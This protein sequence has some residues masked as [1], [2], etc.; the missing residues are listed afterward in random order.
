MAIEDD[1]PRDRET[2]SN[3]ARFW[4]N[5][6]ADKSPTV[7]RLYHHLAIL[8][9]P[10][11]LEQLSLYTRALTCV[12]PFES[13]RGS[14]MTLFKPVLQGTDAINR[15]SSSLET[16]FIRAHGYLFTMHHAEAN[17]QF[18]ATVQELEKDG[19]YDKYISKS[20][21]KFKE[22]G[23]YCADANIAALFE[24]GTPKQGRSK[25]TLR[26]VYEDARRIREEVS[27]FE[28]DQNMKSQ[29]VVN[30]ESDSR[31]AVGL[32]NPDIEALVLS[33]DDS[34]AASISQASRLTTP[35][36]NASLKRPKDRNVY[37]LVDYYLAFFWSLL[38]VQE[39]CKYLEK[40]MVWKIIERDV[41]W[42]A[43]CLFLNDLAAEIPSM[44]ERVLAKAFPQTDLEKSRP[45]LEDFVLRGQQYALWLFP[46]KWFTETIV[47][48][49][50]RTHDPP[51]MGQHRTERIMWLGHRIASVCSTIFTECRCWLTETDQS[52]DTLRFANAAFRGYGLR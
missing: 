51:S 33:E 4:Y 52:L 26:L 35:I 9:R 44:T 5:K 36:L 30:P 48:D 49:D 50:E 25:A 6:A 37:P 11:S 22:A 14:V 45:L 7:G 39:S 46:S 3:V 29:G 13:A 21:S 28:D 31:T 1:E 15:R 18:V 2:W 24:Y 47:E 19:L 42:L 34:I 43:I 32:P 27:R 20:G 40:A 8:A 10:Y 41:P 17:H 38:L 16:V 12:T 23:V